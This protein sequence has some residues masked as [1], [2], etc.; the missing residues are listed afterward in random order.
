MKS[1]FF[2]LW[3]TTLLD[4]AFKS[5]LLFLF[6]GIVLSLLRRASASMRHLVW[7]LL[8]VSLLALPILSLTLP[9]WRL[10]LFPPAKPAAAHIFPHPAL[11]PAFPPATTE[12]ASPPPASAHTETPGEMLPAKASQT[13][14]VP[15]V[16][17]LSDRDGT[18]LHWQG[19]KALIWLIGLLIVLSRTLTGLF[20]VWR[21]GRRGQALHSERL[22]SLLTQAMQTVDCK[23]SVKLLS[24]LGLPTPAPMT[25][26]CIRPIILLPKE[27][28]TWTDECLQ[29]VF[30]HE[31]AHIKRQ[32]WLT[33]L[34][35]QMTCALYWFHPLVWWGAFR[36]Q[37]ESEQACDDRVLALGIK[38]SDYARHLLDVVR[39]LKREDSPCNNAMSMARAPH[40]EGRLKAILKEGASHR[41]LSIPCIVLTVVTVAGLL[42][43]LSALRVGARPANSPT[44]GK[45]LPGFQEMAASPSSTGTP[46]V[47]LPRTDLNSLAETF[48]PALTAPLALPELTPPAGKPLAESA[49]PSIEEQA[50]SP[51]MKNDDGKH[52]PD[53]TS[54]GKPADGLQAG[55][56]ASKGKIKYHV[57]ENITL[58]LKLRNVSDKSITLPLQAAESKFSALSENS[59][60]RLYAICRIS[61]PFTLEPGEEKVVPG[62][63]WSCQL[64]SLGW[65]QRVLDAKSPVEPLFLSPGRYTISAPDSIW[66]GN[67][68]G[69]SST[70]QAQPGTLKIEILA[71][72]DPGVR[73]GQA[74]TLA[75]PRDSSTGPIAWGK[76]VNGLQLG[77]GI[78]G[79]AKPVAGGEAVKT[80]VFLRNISD[81]PLAF[82]SMKFPYSG[83]N[84][85]V[86]DSAGK[87]MRMDFTWYTGTE[88]LYKLNLEPG[89][90]LQVDHPHFFIR[91]EGRAKDSRDT[92]LVAGPGRYRLQ[93]SWQAYPGNGRSFMTQLQ[94][95]LLEFEIVG[96]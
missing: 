59:A 74:P 10:P 63:V 82:S 75:E 51:L 27:A 43:P 15:S 86:S 85:Y 50:E 91:P 34:L 69:S 83:S 64:Y 93:M 8:F 4:A 32:D 68:D 77:I 47:T 31:L 35:V 42:L 30:L 36:L 78:V 22:N 49:A 56:Y 26:G 3:Q 95:S 71:E 2:S 88:P 89:E 37:L 90:S 46:E 12:S 38:P 18:F 94:S 20:A 44:D 23:R 16:F 65:M 55:L 57:G 17:T 28:E 54:W 7:Q 14:I 33:Q 60:I 66:K 9:V 1:A 84:P 29:A 96:K 39:T 72:S 6:A 73:F 13:P 19:W 61:A 41:K 52:D 21:L 40:I 76:P 67:S 45:S 70:I 62:V 48:S 25:W 87:E 81:K 5:L 79:K 80:E 53:K 24:A 92:V 58:G 11:K